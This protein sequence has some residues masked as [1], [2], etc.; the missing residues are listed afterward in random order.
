VR[1]ARRAS[2]GAEIALLEWLGIAQVDRKKKAKAAEA[3]GEE[4]ATPA[5][6]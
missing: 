3:K 4:G 5:K 1:L 2:D 6:S